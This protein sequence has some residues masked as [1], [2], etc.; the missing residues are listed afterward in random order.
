MLDWVCRS[1]RPSARGNHE[2]VDWFRSAS[3]LWIQHDGRVGQICTPNGAVHE[4]SVKHQ[5][6]D[7]VVAGAIGKVLVFRHH[8]THRSRLQRRQPLLYEC[9]DAVDDLSFG[10]TGQYHLCSFISQRQDGAGNRRIEADLTSNF[11]VPKI[12]RFLTL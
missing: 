7:P 2:Y 3:E 6:S 4:R 1:I 8:V 12:T 9:L 11:R 5:V 10:L